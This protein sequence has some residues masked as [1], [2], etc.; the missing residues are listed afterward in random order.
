[1]S[2][3][4]YQK[5]LLSSTRGQLEAALRDSII[6]TQ[7]RARGGR[8]PS[9]PCPQAGPLARKFSLQLLRGSHFG[10][11]LSPKDA[12][13]SLGCVGGGRP[14]HK[15][16]QCSS[17]V[18]RCACRASLWVFVVGCLSML[19]Y[20]SVLFDPVPNYR[21]PC[22]HAWLVPLSAAFTPAHHTSLEHS[23]IFLRA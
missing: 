3:S 13:H 2:P 23:P 11:T 17:P 14:Q 5:R 7:L 18:S 12:V 4:I 9:N 19:L 10:R 15:C 21:E 8:L 22:V 16:R 6:F 20:P 1:M